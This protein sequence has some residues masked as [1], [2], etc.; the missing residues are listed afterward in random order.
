MAL[1][2][3]CESPCAAHDLCNLGFASVWQNVTPAAPQCA[4]RARRGAVSLRHFRFSLEPPYRSRFVQYGI[5]IRLADCLAGL[6]SMRKSR[7]PGSSDRAAFSLF[8]SAAVPL[9]ICA[10]WDSRPSG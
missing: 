9:T 1:F 10:I 4:D 2:L 8:A 5:C 3:F 7:T 6:P